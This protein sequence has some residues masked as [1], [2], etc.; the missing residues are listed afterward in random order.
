MKLLKMSAILT[1]SARIA[2]GRVSPPLRRS[3]TVPVQN[4]VVGKMGKFSL[5]HCWG[6]SGAFA[7]WGM[8]RCGGATK[9]F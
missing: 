6:D 2:K 4:A 7:F 9:L 1:I 8:L 3:G 5:C